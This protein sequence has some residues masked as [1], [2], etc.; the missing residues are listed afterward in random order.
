MQYLL[1]QDIRCLILTSGTLAPLEALT[2]EMEISMPIRLTNLHI[3]EDFQVHVKVVG[4]GPDGESL[5]SS[6]VNR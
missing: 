5:T 6:F 3:I 1:D 2:S 4:N